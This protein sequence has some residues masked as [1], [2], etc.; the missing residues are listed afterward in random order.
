MIC[1]NNCTFAKP[2]GPEHAPGEAEALA[3]GVQEDLLE[4]LVLPVRLPLVALA[5]KGEFERDKRL[6]TSQPRRLSA[7]VVR[8]VL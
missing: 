4:G 7:R 5:E 6:A 2:P 1:K 3:P 8:S